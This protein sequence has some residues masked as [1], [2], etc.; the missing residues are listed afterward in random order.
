M[1]MKLQTVVFGNCVATAW[2]KGGLRCAR[3]VMATAAMDTECR[4]Q[5]R[6]VVVSGVPDLLPPSRMVDKLTIHFQSWRRSQGGDVEVVTYPTNMEGV[7][8]VTFDRAEDAENVV[9]KEQQIMT[10]FPEDYLLTVFPFTRDVFFYVSTAKVDL[11]M[12]GSNQASLIQSLRSAHKSLHFQPVPHRR[13]ATIEGPFAALKALREDLIRRASR[14]KAAASSP[15]AAVKL[16][17]SPLNPGVISHHKFVS[18]VSHSSSKAK[19][20]PADSNSLSTPPQ[21]TGEVSEVQSLQSNTKTQ[22]TSSRRKVSSTIG[23]FDVVGSAEEEKQGARSTLKSPTEY[24]TKQATDS[25]RQ[26]FRKEINAGIGS[27]LSG[28]DLV[29]AEKISA[30][31]PGVDNV[32]QKHTGADR[33]SPTKNHSS[34]PHHHSTNST[35]Y[36]KEMDQSSSAVTIDRLQ[37]RLRD[38]SL[39]SKNNTEDREELSAACPQ[40]LDDSSIWVDSHTFRYIEKY[41]KVQLDRCLSGVQMSVRCAEGT[42]F[43]QISLTSKSTWTIQQALKDLLS[44]VKYHTT[45]LRVHQI[46]YDEEKRPQKQELVKICKDVN[47]LYS[48]VLLLLEDSCIKVVGPSVAGYVASKWLEDQLISNGFSR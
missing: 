24:R 35:D 34:P 22:N 15:T 11:S 48:D 19:R 47:L 33:I 41:D 23:S 18:S 2:K 14:L 7:A 39:S 12:F 32:S 3:G 31:H 10:E 17:E 40:D 5:K 25:H 9:R 36:L 1:K 44:L 43:M 20:E 45:T 26:V 29:S 46:P 27:P 6:T 8:F 21:S 38:V 30:N 13:E 16:R 28:L 42:D 37:T 4:V